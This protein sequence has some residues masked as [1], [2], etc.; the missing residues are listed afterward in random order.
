MAPPDPD[1]R[2]DPLSRRRRRQS[3]ERHRAAG[4]AAVV[5]V[6]LVAVLLAGAVAVVADVRAG[7]LAEG[8]STTPQQLARDR[9]LRAPAPTLSRKLQEACLA[10]RLDQRL[11]RREIL[12]DYLDGAYY[13]HRAYGVQAAAETYF[14]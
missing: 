11:S 6:G 1:P 9:Y 12:Q 5:A 4:R 14:S 13:G 3:R 7:R 2:V 8:G 10:T